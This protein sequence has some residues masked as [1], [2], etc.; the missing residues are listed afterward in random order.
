MVHLLLYTGSGKDE[1]VTASV[2]FKAYREMILHTVHY[3]AVKGYCPRILG[4][5]KSSKID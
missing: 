1:I 5:L 3:R 2:R 4:I